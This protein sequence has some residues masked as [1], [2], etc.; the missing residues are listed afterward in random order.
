MVGKSYGFTFFLD[1]GRSVD[2][3]R[4]SYPPRGAASEISP[5][6]SQERKHDRWTGNAAAGEAVYLRL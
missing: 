2:K 3:T 1:A 4:K 5:H 6:S